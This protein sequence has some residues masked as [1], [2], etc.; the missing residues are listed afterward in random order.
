MSTKKAALQPQGVH[1][2]KVGKFLLFP[3]TMLQKILLSQD[4][5]E[6]CIKIGI[7][8]TAIKIF[9][10]Y[11]FELCGEEIL[12]ICREYNQNKKMFAPFSYDS[13][14]WLEDLIECE[15]EAYIVNCGAE[16][17]PPDEVRLYAAIR[18][19]FYL[20]D[21]NKSVNHYIGVFTEFSNYIKLDWKKSFVAVNTTF[22]F[23]Y[24]DY[25]EKSR[26]NERERILFCLQMGI[27]GIIGM[28][29]DWATTNQ[30]LI[31][32]RMFG[33]ESVKELEKF[34]AAKNSP[35]W[36]KALIEKYTTRRV[37]DGLINEIKE[38]G[39]CKTIEGTPY[40]CTV[41]SITKHFPKICNEVN[42]YFRQKMGK[43]DVHL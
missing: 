1:D 21:I 29:R 31:K 24:R 43:K 27:A 6:E 25:A 38:R 28:R 20:L 12:F 19:A 13:R 17:S 3:T 39:W 22:I 8:H 40:R 9:S 5:Y 37:F 15:D 35:R 14:R 11:D 26:K 34:R 10:K 18:K 2:T 16:D 4:G 42:E 36:L 7:L 30:A 23:R 41:I 32:A 33:F